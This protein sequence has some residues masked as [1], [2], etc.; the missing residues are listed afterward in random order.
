M[1]ATSERPLCPSE[2]TTKKEVKVEETSQH[3][4]S[5]EDPGQDE[6]LAYQLKWVPWRED[7][8]PIVTQNKNGPCPLLALCNAL[9]FKGQLRVEPGQTFILSQDLMQ[10]L[11]DQILERPPHVSNA[12]ICKRGRSLRGGPS[13]APVFPQPGH[14][15]RGDSIQ[16]FYRP[17]GPIVTAL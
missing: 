17:V 5:A 9:I 3:G 2:S 7:F 11:A 10:L 12:L 1:A 16:L 15:I 14:A 13:V 6:P 8:V 4:K